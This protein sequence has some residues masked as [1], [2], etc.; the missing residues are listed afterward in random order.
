MSKK[1]I[2]L[3]ETRD[4]SLRNVSFEAVAAAKTVAEGG[5][6][7]GVVFGESVTEAAKELIHYGAD[8]VIVV[9]NEQ[10]KQYSSDGYTQALMA[11]IDQEAPEGIILGHTS[12]G[13]DLAPRVAG[14]LG[15]GL[16]SDAIAVEE[17]GG[18]I[19][20]TRPI[21]SGKAFEKRVV[22]DGI[23]FAT[24]RPNNIDPLEHDAS[25][26]GDVQTLSVDIKDLRT[27]IKEVLRKA[28]E[29]VDLSEAKVIVAGGRGVKSAEGF[30]PL[31]E[32]ADVLGGA[33]G[34][35][36]GACDAD[37][38][39]YALQIGQ[40]GKVVTPDLYIACGISGAIQ[41]L[42]GMSNSKVIV[43][44]NKDPEANIFKVADYGIVG[45]LFEVVPL[46]TEEMKALLV[47]S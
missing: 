13:K 30:E 8:R 26:S 36:R 43:A 25:R 40:T 45:D 39:D 41:H 31:K 1:V 4:S 21:Y 27:V 12:L 34:A 23:I 5:E 14:K 47:K 19:V 22:T 11:V 35:S 20:F 9:E 7:I 38:C 46:L 28:T 15:S 17:A 24:I 3:G 29:G 2:V 32:L 33:V 10:L 16:I 42:A 37:Y 44:I 6:V 18:N